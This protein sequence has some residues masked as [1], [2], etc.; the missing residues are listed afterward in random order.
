MKGGPV[1]Y[2]APS[3]PPNDA[4]L[5]LLPHSPMVAECHHL[6]IYTL[7]LLCHRE[8]W[9]LREGR[10]T[11]L[12]ERKNGAGEHPSHV[13]EPFPLGGSVSYIQSTHTPGM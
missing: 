11:G 10:K 8:S 5:D 4:P 7:T 1:D 2:A 9:S 13:N 3:S 6:S 12:N